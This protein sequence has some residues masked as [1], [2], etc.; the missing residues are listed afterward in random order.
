[1][2]DNMKERRTILR[3]IKPDDRYLRNL[4]RGL[5]IGN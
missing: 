1:M 4:L 5:F 3:R 2:E